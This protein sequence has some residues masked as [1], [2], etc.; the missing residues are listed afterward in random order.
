MVFFA[1]CQV[2]VTGADVF[3]ACLLVFLLI[4]LFLPFSHFS[5]MPEQQ[6][7]QQQDNIMQEVGQLEDNVIE[8]VVEV[9]LSMVEI[10]ACAISEELFG[11]IHQ[12]HSPHSISHICPLWI[13]LGRRTAQWAST[14]HSE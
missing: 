8:G 3:S 5:V 14:T 11:S 2:A 10:L 13:R 12:V 6:G 1:I 7:N 9:V 4:F